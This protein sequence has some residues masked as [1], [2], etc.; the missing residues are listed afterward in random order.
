MFKVIR[1]L[2]LPPALFKTK[3]KH[4]E[5]N[6]NTSRQGRRSIEDTLLDNVR[7]GLIVHRLYH[8]LIM[9]L[10]FSP[11]NYLANKATW[12]DLIMKIATLAVCLTIWAGINGMI[13]IMAEI[14]ITH[15]QE[16]IDEHKID[17]E[18]EPDSHDIKP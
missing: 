8:E 6:K 17:E 11:I 14:P 7:Y 15:R 10:A 5:Q 12:D 9:P 2:F 4:H 1:R 13:C 3:T 16:Q 18:N